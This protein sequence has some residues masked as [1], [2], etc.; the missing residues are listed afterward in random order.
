MFERCEA[1][2]SDCDHISVRKFEQWRSEIKIEEKKLNHGRNIE[3]ICI[4]KSFEILKIFEKNFLKDFQKW[5]L[6]HQRIIV[7]SKKIFK[8]YLNFKKFEILV[9]KI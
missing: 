1:F 2:L 5:W 4:K 8:N 3:N 7:T 9:K 6:K